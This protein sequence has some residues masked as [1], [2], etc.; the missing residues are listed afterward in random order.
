MSN[1]NDIHRT[2]S[3]LESRYEEDDTIDNLSDKPQYSKA[4]AIDFIVNK[5]CS[6]HTIKKMRAN[7]QSD[8]FES[9]KNILFKTTN[10][11]KSK[12]GMPSMLP[13]VGP[14]SLAPNV[15]PS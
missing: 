7:I 4:G 10:L 13:M 5:P 8:D 9:Y 1:Y 12:V 2:K 11:K 6:I 14:S 3:K 15:G